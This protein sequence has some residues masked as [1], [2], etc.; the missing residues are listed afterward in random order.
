MPKLTKRFLDALKPVDRDTLYRDD[1]LSGFAL[2]VKPSGVR[3]WVV[4]YRNSAGRTRKLAMKQ[5]EAA[6]PDEARQWARKQLLLVAN[7]EDPSATRNAAL[8]AM[9]VAD[10]CRDY[11]AAAEK[12]LVLGKRKR[13]KAETTLATDR[14]RIARHIVPLMGTL[15]VADVSGLDVRRFL[16]AVQ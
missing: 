6:T 13:P 8:G 7:G 10:L 5:K 12:G 1:E 11:L 2:R 3:T 9:T 15:S 14:G 16:N 4:Q